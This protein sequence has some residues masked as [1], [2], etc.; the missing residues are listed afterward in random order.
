M[1]LLSDMFCYDEVVF[2]KYENK[3]VVV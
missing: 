2:W 1:F 3:N